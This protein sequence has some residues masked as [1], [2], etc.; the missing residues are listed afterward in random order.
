MGPIDPSE[1]PQAVEIFQLAFADEHE[2]RYRERARPTALIDVWGFLQ[3]CEPCGFLAARMGGKLVGYAIFVRSLGAI[4]RQALLTGAALRWSWSAIRS[5][6]FHFG[7]LWRIVQ[8]KTLFVFQGRRHR[9]HGD[10]QLLNVAVDPAWQGRGIASEL[11][12]AGLAV[13]RGMQVPEIRLEVRGWNAAAIR[14]YERTGW[15]EVGRTRDLEG[16]WI[17]MVANP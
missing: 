4:Q 9:T 17:V 1:I 13:L 10:A 12:L 3:G 2:S 8:N 15:R 7:T 6:D 16:E 14:V 11:T 5:G